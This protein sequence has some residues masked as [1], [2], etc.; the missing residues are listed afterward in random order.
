MQGG[1]KRLE[2]RCFRAE[3]RQPFEPCEPVTIHR[4]GQLNCGPDG[5]CFFRMERFLTL[6]R[7]WNWTVHKFP[8]RTVRS[9][10]DLTTLPLTIRLS[11]P[12]FFLLE[13]AI[14]W[15]NQVSAS[16]SFKC[17]TLDFCLQLISSI[18]VNFSISV[19]RLDCSNFSSA[20]NLW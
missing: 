14:L 20:V 15:K 10:P 2:W 9:G 5:P 8:S 7:P 17:N 16:P 18:S 12:L 19:W 4:T 11:I 6:N 1:E 13:L 3:T